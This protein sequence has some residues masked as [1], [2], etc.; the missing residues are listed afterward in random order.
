MNKLSAIIITKNEERNIGRCIDSL[1]GVADEI[2]VVDSGS[3]DKT[4]Q[5]CKE[6]GVIFQYHEWAG[7]SG[8][9]NYA[10][11]LATGDWVLSIDADEALSPALQAEVAELKKSA[12]GG[13][14]YRMKRLTN[15]GGSWIRH[16]GW[17]PD[18]KIRIWP[19]G[20]AH[21]AGEIHETIAFDG[22][23]RVVTLKGDL[24]HYSYYSIA[25]LAARQPKYYTL[26]AQEALAKGKSCSWA[27]LLGKT[28]WTFLRDYVIKGGFL[29]GYAGYLV[30]R[31]NAHYT[32]MKYAT[33]RELT[34]K[35][36]TSCPK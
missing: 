26:G 25:E 16:C 17:Y 12:P 19:R 21:W 14:V 4:E 24:L 33:L 1:R 7:F 28:A 35:Q 6:N 13:V 31:M 23:P 11:T 5:I 20:T 34:Q 18:A 2:V 9:K 27:A 32:F 15:F 22:S 36:S 30:C 3:A 29:D 10:E 8:Q